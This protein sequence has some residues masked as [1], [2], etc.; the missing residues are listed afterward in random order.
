M[1]SHSDPVAANAEVAAAVNAEAAAAAAT[2]QPI[3][4]ANDYLL[5]QQL[6]LFWAAQL[7][8]IIKIRDFRE[9]SLPISRIKKIMKSDKEVRMISAESTILLAK[10]CELFIQ[11]LTH[12]SWLKAQECQRRT[13]KK[14]DFFTVLKE[15]ELFDFLVDA[16]SMD[17]TEE[18]APTYVPGM[19]GNI[20]NRIPYC[21]SPMGP[22]AP[23]M[24]PLAPSIG[25][26]APS[27]GS[28]TPSMGP[29]TPSMPTPPRGIMG[30]RAM[31]WVAPSMHVPP[32]LYPRQFRWY[33]AGGNPYAT[34]GSSG[35]GSGD[36]QR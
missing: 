4:N 3:V 15:T 23:P 12:R 10:A 6:R 35:Q 25:P 26:P 29:P 8:E 1:A 24:A 19:L 2:A 34:G 31:P 17:E 16:I 20:P 36:P 27:M 32:P 7:Q 14:I 11:E 21:Y 13:L 28:P 22:P 5:Q 30:K 33:A 18:E 9:H